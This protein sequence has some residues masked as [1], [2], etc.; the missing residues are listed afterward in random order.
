M[1]TPISGG[2]A[3]GRKTVSAKENLR[4][5]FCVIV[6]VAIMLFFSI[7]T[8]HFFTWSNISIMLAQG[9][10]LTIVAMGET[11]IILAGSIDL[12]VGSLIGLGAVLA[13][14][15]SPSM[16][17]WSFLVAAAAGMACGACTGL[18]YAKGKIPSFIASLGMLTVARGIV[19]LYTKGH[20][21]LAKSDAITTLGIGRTLGLPNIVLFALVVV[22]VITYLTNFTTFGRWVRGIGGAERVVGL[23]AVPIDRIKFLLFV[24][25]GLLAALAGAVQAA[26]VGSGVPTTGSGQELDVIAAVVIGGTALTG[27]I[28]HPLGSVLGAYIMTV[29]AT[30][31]DLL[32]IS[33]YPQMVIKGIVLAAAVLVSVDRKR[34][35]IMK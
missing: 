5:Y 3:T 1:S 15:F 2:L 11:L 9:A 33:A 12:S 35:G 22:L 7:V 16:G 27:G 6:L 18:I 4:K 10:V 24:L 29:L 19:Y 14:G 13:A 31:L 8:D 21:I 30:G 34:I 17:I 26:R 25:S 20:P 23:S 28:G 32:G